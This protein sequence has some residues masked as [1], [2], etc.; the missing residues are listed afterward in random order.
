MCG[1]KHYMKTLYTNLH[2]T[3][4]LLSGEKKS[5]QNLHHCSKYIGTTAL[6]YWQDILCLFK[7]NYTSK[8]IIN[9]FAYTFLLIIQI[10]HGPVCMFI[11]VFEPTLECS[12]LWPLRSAQLWQLDSLPIQHPSIACLLRNSGKFAAA[13]PKNVHMLL[14]A[15]KTIHILKQCPWYIYKACVCGK[16]TW[17]S[18]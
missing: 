6:I 1:P 14:H 2:H 5:K 12:H 3:K 15:V 16:F 11:S 17:L 4:Y 10:L 7:T 18:K 8:Y 9:I 13:M